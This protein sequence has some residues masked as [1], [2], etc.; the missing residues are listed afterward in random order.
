MPRW[1]AKTDCQSAYGRLKAGFRVVG[2]RMPE[3]Y[4][5]RFWYA[6]LFTGGEHE[7]IGL[8]ALVAFAAGCV[9]LWMADDVMQDGVR[10]GR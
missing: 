7:V 1:S 4:R 9:V 2:S 6:L 5:W 3:G 10:A 8:R